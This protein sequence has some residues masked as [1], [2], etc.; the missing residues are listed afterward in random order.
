MV[1]Y[2]ALPDS[3]YEV[4]QTHYEERI[5]GT[6]YLTADLEKRSGPLAELYTIEEVVD[7]E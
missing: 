1:D 2:V 7:I 3:V 4:V 5:T 6:H